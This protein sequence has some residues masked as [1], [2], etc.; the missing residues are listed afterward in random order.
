MSMCVHKPECPGPNGCDREAAVAVVHDYN[1]GFTKL[2]N[3]VILWEDGGE[4]RPDGTCTDA[5]RGPALHAKVEGLEDLKR[6]NADLAVKLIGAQIDVL[7][8]RSETGVAKATAD[9]VLAQNAVTKYL[10]TLIGVAA[11]LQIVLILT[12]TLPH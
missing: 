8:A 6:Q 4:I 2:C 9:V 3:G 5:C 1:T 11:L 12:V 7:A 10:A